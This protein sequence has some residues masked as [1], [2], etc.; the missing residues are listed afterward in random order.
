MTYAAYYI[1]NKGTAA[2]TRRRLVRWESPAVAM[3]GWRRTLFARHKRI[4]NVNLAYADITTYKHGTMTMIN[5]FY[6]FPNHLGGMN[7][8]SGIE[9]WRGGILV[10]VVNSSHKGNCLDWGDENVK[11]KMWFTKYVMLFFWKF[12]E[13][14]VAVIYNRWLK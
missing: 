14:R 1:K 11:R 2:H 12:Q 4:G 8:V 9:G 10:Y 7:R 5:Q 6:V 3:R 13:R